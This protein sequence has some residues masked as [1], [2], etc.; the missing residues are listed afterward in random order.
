MEKSA[1]EGEMER[2]QRTMKIINGDE[3]VS[4]EANAAAL[5]EQEQIALDSV[6]N[7]QENQENI[8]R[9]NV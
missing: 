5:Q 7:I 3:A 1:I 9:H 6:R 8:Q 4:R 2:I